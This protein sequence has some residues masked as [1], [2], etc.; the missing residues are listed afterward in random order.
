MSPFHSSRIVCSWARR[1]KLSE[2]CCLLAFRQP[3]IPAF[4]PDRRIHSSVNKD[5]SAIVT[6]RP[7]QIN[8]MRGVRTRQATFVEDESTRLVSG[9]SHRSGDITVCFTVY[10]TTIKH[11]GGLPENEIHMAFDIAIRVVLPT[12]LC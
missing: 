3:M 5:G 8:S 4:R 1:S 2:K 9:K 7:A 10:F 11:C 6:P 12:I